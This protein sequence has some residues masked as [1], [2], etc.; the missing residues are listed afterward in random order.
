[1]LGAGLDHPVPHRF[2]N[3][4]AS[5]LTFQLHDL[6]V[7]SE[8]RLGNWTSIK[9]DTRFDGSIDTIGSGNGHGEQK[10]GASGYGTPF[11]AQALK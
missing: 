10:Q 9:I 2:Q 1:M 6:V 4:T 7:E 3:T 8:H 11:R 5:A